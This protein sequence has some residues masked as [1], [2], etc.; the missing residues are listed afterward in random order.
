MKITLGKFTLT[1]NLSRI[2]EYTVLPESMCSAG[3]GY[4]ILPDVSY[5]KRLLEMVKSKFQTIDRSNKI[6][7]IKYV[8]DVVKSETGGK[9]IRLREAKELVELIELPK[10]PSPALR[11]F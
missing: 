2:P 3:E 8:K 4:Y 10:T 9:T 6:E 7:A 1:I 5:R 11:R